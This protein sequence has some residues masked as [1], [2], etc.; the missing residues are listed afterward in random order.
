ML[1]KSG[2]FQRFLE[3]K[4]QSSDL[5]RCCERLGLT[6]GDRTLVQEV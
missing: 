2:I 4:Q 5:G 3:L 6:A 1:S